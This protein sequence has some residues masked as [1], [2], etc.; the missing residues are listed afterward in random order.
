VFDPG[1]RSHRGGRKMA[2]D[3]LAVSLFDDMLYLDSIPS[4]EVDDQCGKL[5]QSDIQSMKKI[6]EIYTKP[7][8]R[9]TSKLA[10][11]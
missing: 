11:N 1:S 6:Q 10:L 4:A 3:S 7:L 8:S 2:K 9:N 5:P